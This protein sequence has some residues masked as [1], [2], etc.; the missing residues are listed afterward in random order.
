M[1]PCRMP[2]WASSAANNP[3]RPTTTTAHT[4]FPTPPLSR[5]GAS[6]PRTTRSFFGTDR[7]S[8][9]TQSSSTAMPSNPVR[10]FNRLSA[11]SRECR[12]SRILAG[13][14]YRFSVNVGAHMGNKI[15]H[16]IVYTQLRQR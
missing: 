5:A 1:R 9:E 16:E 8:F 12:E 7:V 3:T 2:S 11:A 14:H 10:S 13:F 15:A 4:S 6:W